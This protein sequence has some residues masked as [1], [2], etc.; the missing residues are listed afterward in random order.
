MMAQA[1]TPKYG[2]V[3]ELCRLVGLAESSYHYQPQGLVDEVSDSALLSALGALTG[4]FRP[5]ATAGW[6]CCCAG[7][8]P[9]SR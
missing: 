8:K 2:S 6:A 5:M 4:L 1:M 9:S 3:S 7:K